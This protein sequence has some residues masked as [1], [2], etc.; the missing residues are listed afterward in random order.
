MKAQQAIRYLAIFALSG[1]AIV[2]I[3]NYKVNPLCFFRCEVISG[4]TQTVN[5][6]YQNAQ[7]ILQYPESELIV[8]GSSRG[9]SI[10]LAWV[11]EYS[12]LKALNLSVGGTE[13]Q[14]KAAF[15]AFARKHL[16]LRKVIWIADYFELME[17]TASDKIKYTPALRVLTPE[18]GRLP[19]TD[20]LKKLT[21]LT[22]HN[23]LEASFALMKKRRKGIEPPDRGTSAD[24]DE[25]R[26]LSEISKTKLT[27]PGLTK[28][29]GIIYDGYAHRILQPP[30]EEKYFQRLRNLAENAAADN[31]EFILLIPGYHPEF[32]TRLKREFPEIAK[33]HEIWLTR[34]NGFEKPGIRIL[35]FFAGAPGDDGSPRFWTDGVHFTCHAAMQMLRQGLR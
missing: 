15:L 30:Q 26:C 32:W 19:E 18:L 11:S 31:I 3:F 6:Y 29:I 33:Q 34:L 7:R 28:E 14:A 20:L 10:P 25:S 27:P 21:L 35:N 1:I 22:D 2:A 12:G 8:L 24:K 4:E 23:T 16:K 13:I 9:E 5:T 17:E